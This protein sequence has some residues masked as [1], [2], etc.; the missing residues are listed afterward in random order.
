MRH[1]HDLGEPTYA[2]L[3]EMALLGDESEVSWAEQVH[4]A[5]IVSATTSQRGRDRYPDDMGRAHDSV[6]E[7]NEDD[8][9]AAGTWWNFDSPRASGR[10]GSS[11]VLDDAQLIRNSLPL[12]LILQHL[13]TMA[14]AVQVREFM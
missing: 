6:D 3:L 8:V 9:L 12:V 13:P 10:G 11:H 5:A 14:S 1:R 4:M 2:A 7:N